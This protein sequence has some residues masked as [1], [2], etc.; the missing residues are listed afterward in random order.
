MLRVRAD[1]MQDDSAGL[2]PAQ[3]IRLDRPGAAPS[4]LI[5]IIQ[6]DAKSVRAR[7]ADHLNGGHA[8]A[9]DPDCAGRGM[10][11]FLAGIERIGGQHGRGPRARKPAK[12]LRQGVPESLD[13]RQG[14]Q[15]VSQ[16]IVPFSDQLLAESGQA[17]DGRDVDAFE[18]AFLAQ[19]IADDRCCR[20]E[21]AV[22]KEIDNVIEVAGPR[23]L[24]E[25]AHLFTE[26]F[27]ED[28]AADGHAFRR[29][30]GIG[31]AGGAHDRWQRQYFIGGQIDLDAWQVAAAQRNRPPIG[32]PPLPC[33]L[34]RSWWSRL[35]NRSSSAGS[36]MPVSS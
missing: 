30:V 28:V 33:P 34:S 13:R 5:D 1:S 7:E 16:H 27:L 31:V 22:A 14:G 3:R 9:I 25:R 18:R 35:L 12:E 29:H 20:V 19:D 21:F 26:R 10:N 11:D 8:A 4:L 17:L 36:S 2:R 32:E 15:L 23:P 6:I 24:S